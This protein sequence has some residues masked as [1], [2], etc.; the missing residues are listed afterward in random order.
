MEN[1]VFYRFFFFLIA[2]SAMPA[3]GIAAPVGGGGLKAASLATRFGIAAAPVVI[4]EVGVL[5]TLSAVGAV[6]EPPAV[7][8]LAP[9]GA[10]RRRPPAAAVA[11]AVS[12]SGSRP[13]A[14]AT[15]TRI[16]PVTGAP[17]PLPAGGREQH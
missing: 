6:A 17:G 7:L 3:V 9:A 5:V 8:E 13:I 12:S 4:P 11:A 2:P 16:A 1:K 10:A 14:A 15:R